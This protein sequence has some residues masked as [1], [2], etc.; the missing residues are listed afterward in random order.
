VIADAFPATTDLAI[1]I[2][3]DA[4]KLR[5]EVKRFGPV[6]EMSITA[7]DFAPR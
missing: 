5:D 1:V 6:T 3:G 2:I 7:T 4:A